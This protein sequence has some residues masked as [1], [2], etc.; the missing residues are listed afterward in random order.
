[1]YVYTFIYIYVYIYTC[2]R[3]YMYICIYVYI[4]ICVYIYVYICINV[5]MFVCLSVCLSVCM[6]VCMYVYVYT[7]VH[8]YIYIYIKTDTETPAHRHIHASIHPSIH[9]CIC[10]YKPTCT[11]VY[12]HGRPPNR[13]TVV[14]LT[15]HVHSLF[16]N[17]T[18]AI[19]CFI[20]FLEYDNDHVTAQQH[21]HEFKSALPVEPSGFLATPS[22]A[23]AQAKHCKFKSTRFN[24]AIQALVV[25]SLV[26]CR[27][28]SGWNV[29]HAVAR[30]QGFAGELFFGVQVC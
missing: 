9:A 30:V 18:C 23:M 24:S 2:V 25:G 13:S 29:R 27:V 14:G 16:R 22:S 5:Y 21:Q 10:T 12:I 3:V 6:Y 7:H 11:R 17:L 19:V 15:N 20:I 1:M 28:S 8:I 26:W 4:S